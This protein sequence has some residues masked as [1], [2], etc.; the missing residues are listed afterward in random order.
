MASRTH[1]TFAPYHFFVVLPDRLYPFRTEIR[2]TWVRGVRAYNSRLAHA[3]RQYG[4][5]HYGYALSLY[6]QAFHLAG[7]LLLIAISSF[8]TSGFVL[9]LAV[10]GIGYQE[11]FLQRRTYRQLWRKG[12]AD[13]IVWCAPMGI[14]FWLHLH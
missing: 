3:Y 5:G 6:R 12:I 9:A 1:R 10:I 4:R 13:W 14:Y 2:G 8:L 11:F 7:S